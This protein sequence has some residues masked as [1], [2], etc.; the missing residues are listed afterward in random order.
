MKE[1]PYSAH[2]TTL[3]PA[4]EDVIDTHRAHNENDTTQALQDLNHTQKPWQKLTLQE[5]LSLALLLAHT[6][7]KNKIPLAKQISLEMGKPITQ[8][9]T[10][11]SKS[12]AYCHYV[13]GHALEALSPQSIATSFS[14]SRIGFYPLGIIALIMPW[15]FPLWQTIRACVPALVSGNTVFIKPALNTAGV[16]LLLQ[17]I[18]DEVSSEFNLGSLTKTL[19]LTNETTQHLI[20]HPLVAGIS[21]TG[22]TRAGKHVASVAGA[23]L[24][25]CVLELGGNDAGI[26][27][28]D[29]NLSTALDKI[30]TSRLNNN[31]QSCIATKRIILSPRWHD[32]FTEALYEKVKAISYG[33]PLLPETQQGPIARHDLRLHLHEQVK[34][35]LSQGATKLLGGL[36]PQENGYYYPITILHHV[37]PDHDIFYEETFGPIFNIIK[38]KSDE[39]AIELATLSP[40]GLGG[41][42]FTQDLGKA[43]KIA[44]AWPTGNVFINELV[45]S[46]PALPFGG[47]KDSGWGRELGTFGFYEFVNIKAIVT[48]F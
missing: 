18:F 45:Q 5:R 46:V 48:S 24:K 29:A 4:T 17:S 38:A 31:G 2:F 35:A 41:S 47:I 28:D 10:E 14:S 40:Y 9:L 25:K 22:S 8:A 42:L 20:T 16:A 7:E 1:Q 36:L 15:N 39:H 11:V 30:I 19:L 37:T 3:N 26:V 44:E 6:L 33:N 12:I 32:E 21:L 27:L 23:H 34:K 13:D 43:Q